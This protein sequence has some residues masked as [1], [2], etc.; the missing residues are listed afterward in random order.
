MSVFRDPWTWVRALA[1]LRFTRVDP[2]AVVAA[3][4]AEAAATPAE[5]PTAKPAVRQAA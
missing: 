5:G 3:R 2:L 4:A 1:W